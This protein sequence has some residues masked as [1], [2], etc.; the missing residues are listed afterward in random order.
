MNDFVYPQSRRIVLAQCPG[1]GGPLPIFGDVQST[2]AD[3]MDALYKDWRDQ[4]L[5]ANCWW[6]ADDWINKRESKV[7]QILTETGCEIIVALGGFTQRE[8]GLVSKTAVPFGWETVELYGADRRVLRFPH[9]SGRNRFW[10]WP[11][12][13]RD[14]SDELRRALRDT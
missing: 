2:S 1:Q 6:F 4:A 9:P 14:A 10:N 13:R 7:E 8:L 12:N 3:R 11:Q 5:G